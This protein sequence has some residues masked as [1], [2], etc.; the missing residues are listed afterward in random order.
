MK[1]SFCLLTFFKKYD[2]IKSSSPRLHNLIH[3]TR[4]YLGKRCFLSVI[5]RFVYDY[6]LCG[7]NGEGH[8]FMRPSGRIFCCGS[9]FIKKSRICS[10]FILTKI[11]EYGIIML[12][13]TIHIYTTQGKLLMKDVF[14][15][16]LILC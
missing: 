10:V 14:S 9:Y 11:K 16:K 13:P 4:K 2:I 3:K 5:Y 8:F 15:L 12:R 1:K 6:V 7:D